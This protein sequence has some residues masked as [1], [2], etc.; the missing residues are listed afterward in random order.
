MREELLNHLVTIFVKSDNPAIDGK[1]FTSNHESK[2]HIDAISEIER[3]LNIKYRVPYISKGIN[4][5]EDVL[6]EHV[7]NGNI[8]VSNL[9]S[10]KANLKYLFIYIPEELDEK[11]E[12][13]VNKV[14]S[15]LK[16]CE[17][18]IFKKYEDVFESI[19]ID[20]YLQNRPKK[21]TKSLQNNKRQIKKLNS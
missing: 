12:E 1:M 13:I 4:S 11:Q 3:N 16:G 8:V 2:Y 19:S 15:E 14:L 7:K 10:A 9:S 17:L 20:V 5:I 6:F 18:L 21:L